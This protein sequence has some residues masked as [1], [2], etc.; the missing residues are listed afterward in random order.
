M[1][2]HLALATQT[3]SKSLIVRHSEICP[4]KAGSRADGLENFFG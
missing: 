3:I 2:S 1:L 4:I